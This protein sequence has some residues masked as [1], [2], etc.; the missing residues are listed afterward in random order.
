VRSERGPQ[1]P[2]LAPPPPEL[3]PPKLPELPLDESLDEEELDSMRG[4]TFVYSR[5]KLQNAQR[6]S[7]RALPLPVVLACSMT[8]SVDDFVRL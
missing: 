4:R 6:S 8:V 3:P 5:R 7:T 2:L 1:Y